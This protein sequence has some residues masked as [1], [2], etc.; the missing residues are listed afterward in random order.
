MN[1]NRIEVERIRTVLKAL[2]WNIV[3]EDTRGNEIVLTITKN[4]ALEPEEKTT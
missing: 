4:K 2:G 1:T 3:A